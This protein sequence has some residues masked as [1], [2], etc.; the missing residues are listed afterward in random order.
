MTSDFLIYGANGFLGRAIAR[1]AVQQGHRPLLAGRNE[2]AVRALAAE[3]GLDHR[4]FAVDD[5]ASLDSALAEVPVVLN[6]A[7]PFSHTAE[8]IVEACIRTKTHYLDITGEIPVFEKLNAKDAQAKA[9]GVM[10]LPGVGF[11]VM[12]TDCLALYLKQR[13]PSATHL[14]LAF[15]IDGPAPMPPG[16]GA[17]ILELLPL[18]TNVRSEGVIRLA[19]SIFMEQ[20]FDFGR[21]PQR[22]RRLNWGDVYTAYHSTGIPNI[23]VYAAFSRTLAIKMRSLELMRPLLKKPWFRRLIQKT[24]PNGPTVEQRSATRAHVLGR[25]EDNEGNSATAL[26]HGPE[27]GVTWT[28]E[29]ALLAIKRTLAGQA[30]TGYQTPASAYGPDITLEC[31]GT[32][33]QDL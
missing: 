1:L 33:R 24:L 25:V 23:Q 5:S 13:L 28:S 12:A 32:T 19:P 6:C 27:A 2:S 9:A 7:G 30:P 4:A 8:A 22:S 31:P 17:T 20:D 16:T 3:L 18:G 10:L 14:T 11:D 15:H 29:S 26:L 21:G